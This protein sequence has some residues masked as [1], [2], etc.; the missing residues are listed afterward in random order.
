MTLP[1]RYFREFAYASMPARRGLN[2]QAGCRKVAGL[3]GCFFMGGTTGELL[4]AVGWYGNDQI[5]PLA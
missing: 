5:Y 3:D 1:L 2:F 4:C